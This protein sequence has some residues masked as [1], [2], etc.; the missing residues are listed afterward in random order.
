MKSSHVPWWFFGAVAVFFVAVGLGAV[1]PDWLTPL[2]IAPAGVMIVLGAWP[3]A[4]GR[5]TLPVP[6]RALGVNFAWFQRL[7]GGVAVFIG[8]VWTV[9]GLA[10]FIHGVT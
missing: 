8:A 3:I 10:G 6:H 5:G 1:G 9:A 7:W 2:L 4:A